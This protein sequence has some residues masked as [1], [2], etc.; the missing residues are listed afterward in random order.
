MKVTR[1]TIS[2]CVITLALISQWR[3]G[4]KA[5]SRISTAHPAIN[6][7]ITHSAPTA[8]PA[9]R[10]L[11]A[12]SPAAALAAA[13]PELPRVY[14]NTD[15][16]TPT[17]QTITVTAGGNLQSALDQAQ[18]GDVIMLQAGATFTGNFVLHN[19]N[20]AG[21]V[22]VRTSTSDANLPPGTRV[23]PS[24]ASS[25]PKIISPNSEPAAQTAGGAHHFRFVGI[26]FGVAPGTNIYN[27]ISFGA[28]QTSLAQAPHDLII[29]RCHIHGSADDNARRGVMINSASTA[30]IDSYIS[31]IHEV[32]ADSQAIAGWNGPGPFKIVNNYLEA[33]GENF[34]LGG[35]D[36]SIQNL[37]QS[38]IEFR[39][40]HCFKPLRWKPN[41]PSYAGRYWVVKNLFELKNAQ[42]VLADGNVFENNWSQSQDGM[43]ILFTPRNQSGRAPWSV[44]QDVTFINN[45]VRHS[46]G[47]FNISGPDNEAGVSLPSQR[48]L[49]KNNLIYD[50]DGQRWKGGSEPADGEFLQI[51]GGP[52]YITVDHNTAFQS[53]SIITAD[54][55]PSIGFRY[56]NN[57]SPHNLYGVIGSNFSP[58]NATIAHYFPGAVFQKNVIIG[59]EVKNYP[60]DNFMP[61]SLGEVGLVNPGGEDY[62]LTA[63]SPYKNAG[64]DG[65]DIGCQLD[66]ATTP[67]P[68]PTPSTPAPLSQFASASAA[69][70]ATTV[71]LTA[72]GIVAGF[73]TGPSSSTAFA[74]TLPLPTSLAGMELVVRDANNQTRNAGLFFVSPNQI[75]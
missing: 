33:A 49:I 65:R 35:A 32:G 7:R 68:T 12:A 51:A 3:Y 4:A 38:D 64:S 13:D 22:T 52:L 20:G 56:S 17:G 67:T 37:V 18:P 73:G 48:I 6:G 40:N 14:L 70:F 62:R 9:P 39:N 60:A 72:E 16:V 54:Y 28:D 26:E 58:G 42:R 50:I 25:M 27:I 43:A 10:N 46:G 53:G 36:S 44:V 63:N 19:K 2:V 55:A 34:M 45:I 8:A 11:L 75:N 57:I 47:G 15:Y 1:I 41:D 59:G 74:D 61:T 29:G 66:S 23:T 30:I 5:Q 24:S 31:N 21:W 71:P 69:S